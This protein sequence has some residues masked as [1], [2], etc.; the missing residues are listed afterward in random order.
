[1]PDYSAMHQKLFAAQADAIDG[2]KEIA[3]NLVKAHR[4]VEEM[5]INAPQRNIMALRP[6]DLT[7][8]TSRD[9]S[10]K[11]KEGQ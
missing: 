8:S 5:Y 10:R 1:M 2:L 6:D 9:R 3:D 7:N 4:Q 11:R